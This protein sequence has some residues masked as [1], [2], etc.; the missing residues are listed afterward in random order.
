VS[1]RYGLPPT[2]IRYFG[3]GNII[4]YCHRPF[5]SEQDKK[6]LAEN[7]GKWHDGI[8]KGEFASNYRISQE[9]VEMMN[10]HLINQINEHVG[11]D[12]TLFHLGDFAF[13]QKHKYRQMCMLYRSRINCQNIFLVEGNHDN[14]GE[15]RGLFT[16]VFQ[17]KTIRHSGQ[18]IVISHYSLAVWDKSHRSSWSLYGHSHSTAEAW[19]DRVMPGRRSIDVGVDNI[20]KVF[21]EYRPV[22]FDELQKYFKN[23][24]GHC[25]DHHGRRP[26][27]TEE[28][29]MD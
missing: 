19:L 10:T 8:W 25:I 15:I 24:T 2:H 20:A 18:A 9:G 14:V 11:R 26:D 12:D 13:A 28:E 22:S 5:L 17:L 6:A 27:P 23:S 21:G 16:D 3:H 29:L 7:G 4:K 1:A